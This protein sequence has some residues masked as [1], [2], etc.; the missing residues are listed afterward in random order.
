MYISYTTLIV[1]RTRGTIPY[2][3][4]DLHYWQYMKFFT[5]SINE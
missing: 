5:P 1:L 2:K 3:V 4:I